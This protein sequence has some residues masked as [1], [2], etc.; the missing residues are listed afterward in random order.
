MNHLRKNHG[1]RGQKRTMPL[2]VP[3]TVRTQSADKFVVIV[4]FFI[5]FNSLFSKNFKK[6]DS[7][8]IYEPEPMIT[9]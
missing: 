2:M 7:F 4:Y 1:K 5:Y 3:C 8:F 6:I 9:I